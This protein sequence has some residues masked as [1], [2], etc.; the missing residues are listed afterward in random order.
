MLEIL[1]PIIG[2]IVGILI[3]LYRNKICV[4]IQKSYKKMPQ[5]EEGVKS[6]KV[7]FN[8]RPTIIAILGF[9]IAIFSIMGFIM[10]VIAP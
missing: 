9:L 10:G 2:V 3:V 4:Y 5:Y 1:R 6:L 7:R 8:V